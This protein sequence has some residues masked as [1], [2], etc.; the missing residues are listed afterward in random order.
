M[1]R[2][3]ALL[4]FLILL[5]GCSKSENENPQ[6]QNNPSTSEEPQVSENRAPSI[7][8]QEFTVEENSEGGTLIGI[9]MA[10]DADSDPLSFLQPGT[11]DIYIDPATGEL[12]IG[13]NNA[14]FDFEA[15]E[16]I[17]LSISVSDGESQATAEIT[18]L[19]TDVDDGPLT[20]LEK[21]VVQSF[22]WQTLYNEL[23]F[24]LSKRTEPMRLFIDGLTQK[25]L[26]LSS[27]DLYNTLF[28][29][30]FEIVVVETLE[31][32]NVRLLFSGLVTLQT[33]WPDFYDLA[34]T[35]PGLGGIA[36]INGGR[37]WIADYANNYP[38]IKHELGHLLGLD[39]SLP[40]QCEGSGWDDNSI[41][42]GGVGLAG[43]DL[44]E[45]DRLLFTLLYH[46][47]V[48]DGLPGVEVEN[49]LIETIL[50]LR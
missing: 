38:T 32:S 19:I 49:R 26:L 40:E 27:I 35:A 24:P 45:V 22:L 46:P 13:L 41:M 15:N 47:N 1:T 28:T 9:V 36:E 20:N 23:D 42:C 31:E 11:D 50:S 6:P 44:N 2:A 5:T 29:D 25:Q 8:N 18:I 7:T 12:F 37:I 34:M 33:E 17:V 39:H 3:L 16:E 4:A 48:P 14:V 43:L 10:S 21:D 30:G